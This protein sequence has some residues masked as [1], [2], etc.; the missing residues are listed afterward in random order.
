M[1]LDQIQM[2]K[3]SFPKPPLVVNPLNN[4]IKNFK[5][6]FVINKI[7]DKIHLKNGPIKNYIPNPNFRQI[8]PENNLLKGI[9]KTNNGLDNIVKDQ[10]KLL[11]SNNEFYRFLGDYKIFD[12]IQ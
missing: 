1:M 7:N 9:A 4:H 12:N 6:N 3:T 11:K 10:Y 2:A 5:N 8:Q